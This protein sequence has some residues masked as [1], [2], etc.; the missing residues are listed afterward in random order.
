MGLSDL[1]AMFVITKHSAA[2][3]SRLI[4]PNIMRAKKIKRYS[5]LDANACNKI[6]IINTAAREA[7]NLNHT[8]VPLVISQQ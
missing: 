4:S 1:H 8:S 5:K 3:V 7:L 2:L 6:L